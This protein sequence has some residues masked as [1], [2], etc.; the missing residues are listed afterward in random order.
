MMMYKSRVDVRLVGL[1][2]DIN[3]QLL[4]GYIRHIDP[5]WRISPNPMGPWDSA[6][7]VAPPQ[8]RPSN[9]SIGFLISF[10]PCLQSLQELLFTKIAV[11][12]AAFVPWF[13]GPKI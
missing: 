5:T 11:R 4:Y 1:L 2:K 6:L 8:M 9:S 12:N 7:L 3:R 13:S 10:L